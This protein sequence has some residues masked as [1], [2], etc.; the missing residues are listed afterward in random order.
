VKV[1]K[2]Q[3]RPVGLQDFQRLDPARALASFV[4][5][6]GQP[7]RQHPSA[8]PIVIDYEDQLV[9]AFHRSLIRK[10]AGANLYPSTKE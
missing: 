8:A 6:L 10:A 1:E 5:G 9:V 3:R 4:S 7:A 2:E